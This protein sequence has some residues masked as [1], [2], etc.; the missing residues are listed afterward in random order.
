MT[1]VPDT[2]PAAVFMGLRDVAVEERPTPEPRSG[3]L[4]LEVSHCGICGSDL[5]FLLE[6]GGRSGVI[7]GHEYS[8]TVAALGPDV[9][10]WA[11]GDRVIGGPS[12][13]CGQCEYCLANRTSLCVERG[14]VG[15]D[16]GDWQGA[17]AGYKIVRAAG[18]LRVPDGWR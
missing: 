6:W 16:D 8:G 4:L 3:E 17:F 14:G 9:T 12:P 2:M 13:K 1:R 11:V 7:E 5:H 18:T 15:G 10:G